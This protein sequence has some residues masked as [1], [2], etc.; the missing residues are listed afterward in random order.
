[1]CRS[2][3][4]ASGEGLTWGQE[5][6]GRR[7]GAWVGGKGGVLQV[8]RQ[9]CGEVVQHLRPP[10]ALCISRQSPRQRQQQRR[11]QLHTP[12]APPILGIRYFLQQTY[13]LE[14]FCCILGVL[15]YGMCLPDEAAQDCSCIAYSQAYENVRWG[16]GRA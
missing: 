1:M 6:W 7:A 12:A 10:Q 4:L 3:D 14:E 15:D 2:T 9:R 5:R 16:M 11:G 8:L 13:D